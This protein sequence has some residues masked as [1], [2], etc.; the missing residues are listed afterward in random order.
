M[1]PTSQP[2]PNK[3]LVTISITFGTLM[4]AIDMSI[5][6]VAIPHMRGALGASVD[7]I[8]WVS[9]GYIIANVIVMPLVA[10]LGRRFG[11]KKVYQS[12]MLLF[13]V[14]SFF[15][16][17]ARSLGTLVFFRILQGLGAGGL[18]PTEQAILRETFPLEEQATA[19]S[20][21]GL[22]VMIGPAIGPTLGGWLVDHQSWPWI[23]Y[24]NLPVGALGLI[25]VQRFVH[26]PEFLVAGKEQARREKVDYLGLALLALGLGSFQLLLERG[27]QLDWFSSREIDALAVVAAIALTAFVIR[28]L[29]AE[30]PIVDLSVLKDRCFAGGTFIGGLLGLS[31]FGSLFILPLFFQELRGLSAEQSGIEL[32]PRTLVMVVTMPIA[33]LLFNRVGARLMIAVG[34]AI[35]GYAAWTMKYFTLDSSLGGMVTPQIIQ[36]IGFSLVFVALSTATLAKLPK[37]KMSAATGLY[38][39]VRNLG[40][41]VG[42]AIIAVLFERAQG[43]AYNDLAGHITPAQPQVAARLRAAHS[44]LASRFG[45]ASSMDTLRL[46]DLEVTRQVVLLA[47]ERVFA[48]IGL[49]FFASIPFVLLLE[50]VRPHRKTSE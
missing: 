17:T 40:G 15:C 38:N 29:T 49:V 34:L 42:T 1:T 41:S 2:A 27:D 18:Q 22:A 11:R 50:N 4:G 3:W 26:D 21:F 23:F 37:T 14:G 6:N 20:L 12:C 13:L 45:F 10:W 8:T 9:T 24:V 39:L 32:M 36:G 30:H 16:G 5:V 19:M 43:F 28:E 44:L 31:L 7:E 46:L 25:M 47:F 33:G 48:I 35:G